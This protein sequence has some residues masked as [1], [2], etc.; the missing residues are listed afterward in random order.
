MKKFSQT[1]YV[2][3]YEQAISALESE[4]DNLDCKHK[5]VLALAQMGSLN[6]AQAE[7]KRY[8]LDK[9]R[10]HEDIMGLGGRLSKDLYLVSAGKTSL[11]H[12]RD[13][14]EKYE[15]AFKDTQGYYSGVNAATMALLADMPWDIIKGPT[16]AECFLLLEEE[17]RAQA[18]LR[19]AIDFDPLNYTAHASTLKQFGLILDKRQAD[20]SWLSQFKPPKAAHFAGHLWNHDEQSKQNFSERISDLIQRQDIGFGYG[21]LA[22]GADILFAEALLEEGAELNVILPSDLDSFIIDSVE[23]YGDKWVGRFN[24]CIEQASSLRCLPKSNGTDAAHL[25]LSA[26]MAMGQAILRSQH[27][28]VAPVQ[29]LML[30]PD[31]S[32]SL[33]LMHKRDWD[34]AKHRYHEIVIE[35]EMKL[36]PSAALAQ[37]EIPFLWRDSSAPAP[38]IFATLEDAIARSKNAIMSAVVFDLP[39]ATEALN[40]LVN[41]GLKDSILVSEAVASYALLKHADKYKVTFAGNISGHTDNTIRTYTVRDLS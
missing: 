5:A 10:H 33:T 11:A 41:H 7:F 6:F 34:E 36:A 2:G 23:P 37:T 8:E 32:A 9:V 4:P 3:D 21:A 27:L 35:N 1:D 29:M 18:A 14:A 12:A 17:N 15:A 26:R 16:R 20:N 24:A 40:S 39:D 31:R 13:A 25:I 38:Q 30:D 19:A 22:A 28:D